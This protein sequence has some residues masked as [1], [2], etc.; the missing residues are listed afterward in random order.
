MLGFRNLG[1]YKTV[2]QL[3]HTFYAFMAASKFAFFRGTCA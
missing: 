3:L 1:L 2:Q